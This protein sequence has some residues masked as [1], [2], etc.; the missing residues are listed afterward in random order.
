M[1]NYLQDVVAAI[2]AVAKD[3]RTVKN[4]ADLAEAIEDLLD[5]ADLIEIDHQEEE[6]AIPFYPF[7]TR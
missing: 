4:K 2:R 5:I 6:I 3:F 1:D 7:S